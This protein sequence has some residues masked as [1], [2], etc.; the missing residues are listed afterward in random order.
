MLASI[1]ERHSYA[2]GRTSLPATPRRIARLREHR[3]PPTQQGLASMLA[4]IKEQ[5]PYACGRTSLLA[6]PRQTA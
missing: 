6:T 2:W 1:E 4:S 5:C 3:S